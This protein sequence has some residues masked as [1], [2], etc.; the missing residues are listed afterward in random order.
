MK[1]LLIVD[2]NPSTIWITRL[3]LGNKYHYIEAYNVPSAILELRR[4]QDIDLI[5]SDLNMPEFS[6]IDLV[7]HVRKTDYNIPIIILT[8]SEDIVRK[9][10]AIKEGATAWIN[11]P[12]Q[13]AE[14]RSL[15]KDLSNWVNESENE[16]N[17]MELA[18]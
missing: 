4:N 9:N 14:F 3:S 7:R 16:K 8:T 5:I 17:I 13:I 18:G 11:K 1:T 6:G 10:E 15:V 2:D 12:F